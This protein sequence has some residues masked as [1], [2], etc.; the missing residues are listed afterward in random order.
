MK[1]SKRTKLDD[2]INALTYIAEL[3]QKTTNECLI[4]FVETEIKYK[5]KTILQG[6]EPQGVR[7]FVND[8]C[9]VTLQDAQ[10]YIDLL[11]NK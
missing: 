1:L 5:K 8:F 2:G 11:T 6:C 9:F 10:K 3:N 4:D 7:Y